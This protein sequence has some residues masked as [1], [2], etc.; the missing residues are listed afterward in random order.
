[1]QERLYESGSFI[2]KK[3]CHV[4]GSPQN[5]NAPLNW[6]IGDG[7]TLQ[8]YQV[9]TSSY[10]ERQIDVFFAASRCGYAQARDRGFRT[11]SIEKQPDA[12]KGRV[13]FIKN[14]YVV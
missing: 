6:H 10:A 8:Q 7:H 9:H 14:G 13:A 12:D 1:M 5:W 4:R 11:L 2:Q 3:L